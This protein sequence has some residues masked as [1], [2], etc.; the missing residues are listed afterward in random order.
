[1]NTRLLP[2][3]RALRSITGV[4]ATWSSGARV[5]VRGSRWR[6]ARATRF[7]DCEALN[8]KGES[9]S[10]N[11][12]LLLPF[13]R[14]RPAHPAPLRVVSRRR[15]AHEVAALA[16]ATH[17]F[18]GLRFCPASI[19]LYPYQLEP[20]LAILRHGAAR[21]L[22][23][24]D[25]GMGKSVEGGLVVRE[26]VK[27][28]QLARALIL[29]PAGL[30]AQWIQELLSL[31]DL[32]AF[33]AD[34]SW[35]HR[36][37]RELPAD[38][39]PWAP[40]GVYL[41]SIDFVK[42]PEALF[43]LEGVHWDVL[44]VDEA[45]TAAAGTD[46][47][48]AVHALACRSRRLML[49]TATP[50]QGDDEQFRALC[51]IGAI[52]ES[53]PIVVFSR[54]RAATFPETPSVRSSVRRVRLSEAER[55]AHRLLD[56]YT[57]RV[58]REASSREDRAGELVATVLRKRALSSLGSLALSVRRRLLLLDADPPSASQL[59][60]SWHDEDA[61]EDD[62]T[63]AVLSARGWEDVGSERDALQVIAEAAAV[64]ARR[65]SKIEVLLR[66]LRRARQS[67]IVFSEYR[68]TA[69]RVRQSLVEAGHRVV[70]LHG[71]IATAARRAVLT[72]FAAGDTILVATDAASEGLNLH[73][74]CRLV[75]HFEL[76][77]MPS[78]LHQRCGRLNRI[79]QRRA[80][81][82]TALV[83]D[84]TAEEL[85][86]LPIARRARRAGTFLSGGIG[87]QI[88]ESVLARHLFAGVPVGAQTPSPPVPMRTLTLER[89]AID[90]AARLETLR[91]V[92]A[93]GR[94]G[95]PDHP[96]R[97]RPCLPIANVSRPGTRADRVAL[98][99]LVAVT[100]P[101][102][103][104]VDQEIVGL[105]IETAAAEWPR[106]ASVVRGQVARLLSALSPLLGAA[107]EPRMRHR[108][109]KV[110][111]MCRE[112]GGAAERRELDLRQAIQSAARHMVQ[113][114]LFDRRALRNESQRASM[115]AIREHDL[116]DRSTWP[117]ADPSLLQCSYEVRGV[118]IGDLL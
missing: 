39:N 53:E 24:D 67:A 97:Q 72:E 35:L 79:G 110:R 102:S 17:P 98:L 40:P 93:R 31:F 117:C 46:R 95:R 15:W 25:V 33:D 83:A 70:V 86:L 69:E 106:R 23:G 21:V 116:R 20:A 42:R 27:S 68:D 55:A 111:E 103:H 47:R 112:A 49:L 113:P 29:C 88:A 65:E 94:G 91:K 4:N 22:V 90:E 89:E 14:P 41:A 84:H 28:D 44:V 16:S 56:A 2:T 3:D 75:I 76:P 80:V 19:R 73:H 82:E 100:D 92:M 81:H 6:V 10:V 18:G 50:H 37:G 64:A 77:W 96:D 87:R 48:A 115:A 54:S 51:A 9:S 1:M 5:I 13:D 58:W 7:A 71:G 30:R 60:L 107:L 99:V 108:L 12:T 78:R 26:V 109:S 114:G 85:V 34:A 11:R 52:G 74:T 105:S 101:A 118:W 57:A 59:L 45:H 38:V 66:L 32:T 104:V 62:S 61:L 63:D 8:L 36:R 43:P